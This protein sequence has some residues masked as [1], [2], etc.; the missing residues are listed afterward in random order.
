MAGRIARINPDVTLEAGSPGHADV[1]A[2]VSADVA[3]VAEALV[4]GGQAAARAVASLAR[5]A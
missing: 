4:R 3:T 2:D 5:P 1:W